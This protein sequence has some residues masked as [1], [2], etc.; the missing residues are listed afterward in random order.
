MRTRGMTPLCGHFAPSGTKGWINLSGHGSYG[1]HSRLHERL[2]ALLRLP[3]LCHHGCVNTSILATHKGLLVLLCAAVGACASDAGPTDEPVSNVEQ[4]V[5]KVCAGPDT[6]S[7][8]DVSSWQGTID[9]GKVAAAGHVYAIAR[10]SDGTYLD[11]DF[12]ANWAGIK[13]AG[14]IRGAYQYF[15]PGTAVQTQVDIVVN[16]VGKLGDGDL[17][18]TIDIEKGSP[19]AAQ[20]KDWLDSVEQATG[21]KPIIYTGSYFWESSVNSAAFVDH[22]LWDA[23]YTTGCPLIPDQWSNWTFWQY[24]SSGSVPGIS[25]NV[26]M[27]KFNGT[28]AQLIA[29]AG[30]GSADGPC[31]TL[32]CWGQRHR[33]SVVDVDGDGQADVCGRDSGGVNCWLSNG[34]AFPTQIE[35]PALSDASGWDNPVYFSTIQYADMNGDGKSDVCGRAGAGFDCWL[36]NGSAFPDGISTT[37]FSN[38]K[39]W[40]KPEYYG[41]VQLADADG[42]GKVDVC[43]RA[44]AGFFCLLSTGS[45]FGGKVSMTEMSDSGG[46][47]DP[48]YYTTIQMGDV[49]GDRKADVCGRGWGGVSCWLS[50]GTA[51]GTKFSEDQMSD[52]S[53]WTDPKYYS[54][55]HLADVNGDGKADVCGRSKTGILCAIS[56]G[57]SFASTIT[58]DSFSDASGWGDVKYYGT[59]QLG[60]VNGDGKAD[61]CGR[62]SAGFTC[63]LSEGTKF[64]AQI[65]TDEF[66]NAK[67][68]D[69]PKYYTTMQL[70]DVDGDGKADICGRAAAGVVCRLSDGAGFPTAVTGPAFSNASGWDAVKYYGTVQLVGSLGGII[71]NTGGSGGGGA[72]GAGPGQGGSGAND[73]GADAASDGGAGSIWHGVTTSEDSSGCQCTAAPASRLQSASGW[74]LAVLLMAARRRRLSTSRGRSCRS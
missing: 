32:P 12:A 21:K 66:S 6:V 9:W 48:K 67:G 53:G 23:H 25:G 42:D 64:G 49:N 61:F 41:T 68:W 73:A 29:L 46:W 3:V 69:D 54:T 27:D 18:V 63:L 17:P 36:S 47:N 74:L 51:F 15:E 34:T 45:G 7:G 40:N 33:G 52:T 22:P 56:D 57:K 70:G 58:S 35:G 65:S 59:I 24:S 37:E 2:H 20:V 16:A 5:H 1:I 72:G 39:G 43:G 62:A 44:G 50:D 31:A 14:M 10:I 71:E 11:K 38:D 4:A 28:K 19:T 30:G 55:I 60:D 8:I 26:D 13:A